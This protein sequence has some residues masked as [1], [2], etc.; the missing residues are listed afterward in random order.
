MPKL[1]ENYLNLKQSYLFSDRILALQGGRILLDGS[2]AQ[3]L[4]RETI[5]A[6]YGVEVDVVKLYDDRARVCIPANLT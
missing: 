6:L 3:V 4:T 1:N 5:R 2:P